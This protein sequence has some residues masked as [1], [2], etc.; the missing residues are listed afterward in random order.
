[1]DV[2]LNRVHVETG[3]EAAE[4]A[5]QGDAPDVLINSK[6]AAPTVIPGDYTNA[7]YAVLEANIK[8]LDAITYDWGSNIIVSVSGSARWAD[9]YD[10]QILYGKSATQNLVK[11]QK[12]T[13]TVDGI[14]IPQ[15]QW[16]NNAA[17]EKP[18]TEDGMNIKMIRLN[19]W[20]YLLADMGSG[21]TL[22]GKLAI[23]ETAATEFSVY[24]SKTAVQISNFSVKTGQNAALAALDGIDLKV[25]QL[26]KA[27]AVPVD[28]TQWTLEGKLS[29]A[30]FAAGADYRFTVSSNKSDWRRMTVAYINGQSKWRGQ[31]VAQISGSWASADIPGADTLTGSGLWVRFV[32]DG[33]TLSLYVSADRENWTYI[34]NCDN[35]GTQN[36]VVYIFEANGDFS[37]V[38]ADMTIRAGLPQSG[39]EEEPKPGDQPEIVARK[40][41]SITLKDLPDQIM[42]R[43]GETFRIIDA[44]YEVR[45]DNGD[46][47]YGTITQDM[48]SE[49]DMTQSGIQTVYVDVC[50]DGYKARLEFCIEILGDPEKYDPTVS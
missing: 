7:N 11:L 30:D 38:L 21:Y 45:Y 8:A 28:G 20:V 37:P 12:A 6:G 15:E 33:A 10:M 39:T 35:C 27:F 50:H 18:F 22:V 43:L 47:E 23:P 25:D 9:N 2:R 40:V 34:Q 42:Y 49:V 29:I 44:S 32:R 48:C 14:Q 3:K 17:F 16:V 4:K 26:A 46:V 5:L 31:S 24:N 36:G 13:T 19:T 41:E 1:M